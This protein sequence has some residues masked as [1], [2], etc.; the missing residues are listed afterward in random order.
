[1][2]V[3]QRIAICYLS[4][5]WLYLLVYR[6]GV[7]SAGDFDRT[8]N[9]RSRKV[10][11]HMTI[12]AIAAIL[13]VGYWALLMFVPVPGYGAG[14]LNQAIIWAPISIARC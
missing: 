3:L 2:G 6:P 7:E 10:P 9:R 4:A 8:E 1:M 11:A 5:A 12:A 13:L 14:H